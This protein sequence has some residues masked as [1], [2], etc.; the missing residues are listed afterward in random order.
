SCS[1]LLINLVSTAERDLYEI[2]HYVQY[3]YFGFLATLE[4]TSFS[5]FSRIST[6][7]TSA[8]RPKT[9]KEWC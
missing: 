4:M 5:N 9:Y 2:S 8:P 6:I 3:S 7:T 1:Y